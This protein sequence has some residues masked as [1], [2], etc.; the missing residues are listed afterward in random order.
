MPAQETENTESSK[1]HSGGREMTGEADAEAQEQSGLHSKFEA[2]LRIRR[3]DHGSNKTTRL[4]SLVA[5]TAAHTALCCWNFPAS[6]TTA[7]ARNPA[8]SST[9]G[10]C[11]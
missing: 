3:G 4:S 10:L 11:L 9:G 6:P 7:G 5:I 8:S 2:S 1:A